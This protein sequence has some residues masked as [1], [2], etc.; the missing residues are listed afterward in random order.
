MGEASDARADA[1]ARPRDRRRLAGVVVAAAV[2]AVGAITALAVGVLVGTNEQPPKTPDPAVPSGVVA[3]I[4]ASAPSDDVSASQFCTGV[5]VAIDQVLTAAH[6]VTGKRADRIDVILDANNLCSPNPI[7]GERVQVSAIEPFASGADAALLR[8]ASASAGHS[9]VKL[10]GRDP[11]PGDVLDAW[12]WSSSSIGGA[13]SC[14]VTARSLR[15]VR[16]ELCAE[17]LTT[18]ARTSSSGDYLC[19]VPAGTRNTCLGDSGGP[20]F[21]SDRRIPD[22]HIPGQR[23]PGQ[24]SGDQHSS[25]QH[26]SDQQSVDR[27]GSHQHEL[28]AITLSGRG[29]GADDPGLYLTAAAIRRELA[30]T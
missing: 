10:S 18:T 7:S 16:L 8:L 25:D 13:T 1:R 19:G 23:T 4:L 22:Q 3:V 9:P 21:V 24:H 30:G 12:G 6:C 15:A 5:L 27:H 28:A 2:I 20:L 14:G 11:R 17:E 26:S 29:C